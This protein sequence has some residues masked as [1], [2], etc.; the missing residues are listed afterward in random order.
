M[1][2][3]AILAGVLLLGGCAEYEQRQAAARDAGDD[4][5][6]RSYGIQPGTDV[7]AQ[8]RMNLANQ[9]A[10]NR[11]VA[12]EALLRPQPAPTPYMMPISPPPAAGPRNCTSVV[13]GNVV[14]T[15]CY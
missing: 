2:V 15:N 11:R 7:Y 8:C 4:S 14:N 9:L 3:I 13:S 10:A 1:R 6:C 5:Q 12:T